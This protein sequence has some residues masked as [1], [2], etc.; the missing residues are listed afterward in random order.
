MMHTAQRS[1]AIAAAVSSALT[2]SKVQW[3]EA[4][5]NEKTDTSNVSG[6]VL[7]VNHLPQ[8]D[9]E[10]EEGMTLAKHLSG[11]GMLRLLVTTRY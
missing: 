1:S 10:A 7:F 4:R 2:K 9:V 8:R 5:P 3:T 11:L 6:A